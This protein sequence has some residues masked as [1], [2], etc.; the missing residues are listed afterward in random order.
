MVKK[1]R[2][3]RGQS[4]KKNSWMKFLVFVGIIIGAV[5]CGYVTARFVIAPLLGY[6]TQVLKLDFPSKLT[7]FLED[8]EKNRDQEKSKTSKGDDQNQESNDK[9][10]E[11]AL[12]FGSFS[13]RDGAKVLQDQ[14]EGEGI[15]TE[16]EEVD[17]S[18]KVMQSGFDTKSAALDALASLK[19]Q[20]DV[21]V[22]VTVQND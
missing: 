7:S 19:D 6:D 4:G 22:F 17:G 3:R 15:E 10:T 13:S 9:K 2:V 14:L 1:R 20:K 11:Y 5:I 21:D 8:R 16:I 18:Y 12:Q